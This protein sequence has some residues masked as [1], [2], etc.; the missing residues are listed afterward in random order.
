MAPRPDPSDL[1]LLADVAVLEVGQGIALGYAGH[2][3][4]TLGAAVTKVEPVDGDRLRRDGAEADHP[5]GGGLFRHLNGGKQALAVDLDHP[6]G[7]QL[8]RDLA[9]RARVVLVDDGMGAVGA[10][11]FEPGEVP[12]LVRLADFADDGPYRDR[13]ASDLVL[14]ASAGWVSPRGQA[15]VPP[16]QVGLRSHEY[17]AGTYVA[18]AALAAARAERRGDGPQV[19]HVDRMTAVFNTVAYDMLRRETLTSLGYTRRTHTAYIPGVL[20]CADGEVA[21]NCLTGQHWLD[22]CSLVGEPEYADRYLEMRYDGEEM[23]AFH[24]TVD[25]WFGAMAVHDVVELCQA[26]RVPATPITT[27]ATIASLPPYAERGFFREGASGA[28]VPGPPFRV[29][30]GPV[31]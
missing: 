5:G 18:V 10:S 13:A 1:H 27:G 3:L 31:R 24:L 6:E 12:A 20:A 16:V 28:T 14:Q 25:P 17:A 22:L 23:A 11:P 2:L 4:A 8:T 15:G 26:F 19:V 29:T 21:V 30:A 9:A 7:A